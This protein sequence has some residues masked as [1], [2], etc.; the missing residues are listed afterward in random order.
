VQFGWR[1]D[2]SAR[3]ALI[4]AAVGIL[5]AVMVPV[6]TRFAIARFGARI[7][8]P[9]V[10]RSVMPRRRRE[11]VLVPLAL[12]PAVALEELLFR[13]LLLGG[14]GVFVPSLA[15]AV[16]WSIVFGMMHA[17]Q[18]VLGI[19]VAAALGLLLAWLFLFTQTLLAPLVAHYLINLAQ[20]VWASRDKFWLEYDSGS[21]S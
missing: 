14:F 4:G 16:V 21:R 6:V 2:A 8:S 19:V 12:V 11:W 7:Y 17:P 18:G 20:L 15:L 3:A 10:I 13:S 9:I 1:A 5:V